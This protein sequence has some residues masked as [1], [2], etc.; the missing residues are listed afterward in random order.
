MK[1]KLTI[2]FLI[3]SANIGFSQDWN[4]FVLNQNSYFKQQYNDSAKVE[5]FLLDS[6]LIINGTEIL[7]F[8]AISELNPDCY[9]NIK[10]DYENIGWL[11][12]PNKIDS[13]IKINDSLLFV[14]NYP[15]E[16]DTFIFKPYAKLNDSWVTNGISITCTRLGVTTILGN[17][18][19]IKIYTCTGNGYDGIEFK[20]SK[21]YGFIKF[22]PLNEFLFHSISSDF[23]PYL[24]LIGYSNGITSVGY[25]QPD[26]NDY[27]HLSEGD[28]LFW[29]DYTNP[30]DIAQHSLTTYYVDSITSSYINSD[31]VYY[32][33][34]RTSYTEVG[35]ISHVGN[36]STNYLRKRE[37]QMLKNHTSW[38]GLKNESDHQSEM[39]YFESL[40]FKIENSDT[41]T[42]AQYRL[43]GLLVD[44]SNCWVGFIYDYNMTVGFSTREGQIF[45]GSYVW[46]EQTLTLIGSKIN[47]IE[48]GNTEIPTGIDNI[49]ID[50]LKVYPNPFNDYINIYSPDNITLIEIFDIK[51][52][53]I[54]KSEINNGIL[55]LSGLTT[56]S[57]IAKLTDSKAKTTH[58]KLL[59]Q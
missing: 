39:F 40:Y 11:R 48:Y 34:K 42:Y 49:A 1:I 43:P 21:N 45:R 44:K 24:E 19:S 14:A 30:D 16:L 12:N 7:F 10:E 28:M 32:D 51:G 8:N 55:N 59:K 57:Y 53:L 6:I 47:G 54:L 41:I 50:N 17:Q 25:T 26:F 4:P 38:F 35:T 22:L 56:G 52:N 36:Y 33:Y 20:L 23:P 18:D 9:K 3:L 27:F 46:W 13:L 31:S 15:N 37:G 2:L 58:M 5:N 29:R